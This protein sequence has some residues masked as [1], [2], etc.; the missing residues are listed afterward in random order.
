MFENDVAVTAGSRGLPV[1]R[2]GAV[3]SIAKGYPDGAGVIRSLKLSTECSARRSGYPRWTLRVSARS[4]SSRRSAN[5]LH[6]SL[7]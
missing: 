6:Q 5:A 4:D 2:G 3:V 7:G 1:A